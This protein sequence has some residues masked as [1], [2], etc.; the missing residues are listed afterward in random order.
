MT[1]NE[2]TRLS[3]KASLG[4][5]FTEQEGHALLAEVINL[6]TVMQSIA[7]RDEPDPLLVSR[8]ALVWRDLYR[9]AQQEC[10]LALRGERS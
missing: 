1:P 6:R 4:E 8:N 10:L 5:A 7:H 2:V 9:D 3:V